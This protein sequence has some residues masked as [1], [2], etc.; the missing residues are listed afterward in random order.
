MNNTYTPK[1]YIPNKAGHDYTDAMR[2]GELVYVTAGLQNKYS[3]NQMLRIWQDVLKDSDSSDC[4]VLTGLSVIGSIGCSVFAVKHQRVN[5]LL[6]KNGKY[7]KRELIID[8]D[9]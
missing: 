9:I 2:Y 6:W 3:V 8:E 4:I 5:L 7:I 1:V